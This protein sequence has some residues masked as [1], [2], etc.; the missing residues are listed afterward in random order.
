METNPPRQQAPEDWAREVVGDL[1]RSKPP[2][3]VRRGCLAVVMWIVSCIAPT[4]LLDIMFWYTAQL[5][6]FKGA[7]RNEEAKK[8]R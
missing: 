3:A 4:W 6:D 2:I 5:G 8:N 7:L 1:L